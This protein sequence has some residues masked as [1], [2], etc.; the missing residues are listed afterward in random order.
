M[1]ENGKK[2]AY[3]IEVGGKKC[4]LSEPTRYV[5]KVVYS[6]LLKSN[7]DLNLVEAGEIILNSCWVSGDK[8]IKDDD[9]LFIAACLSAAELI[10]TKEAK[11]KKL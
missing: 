2:A 11:L 6:K 10:E 9:S 8:E 7:G 1:A 5:L 4:K 3:E